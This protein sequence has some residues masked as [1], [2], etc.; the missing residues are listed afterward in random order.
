MI[1]SCLKEQVASSVLDS[2]MLNQ[3]FQWAPLVATGNPRLDVRGWCTAGPVAGH[4]QAAPTGSRSGHT[5]QDL[6]EPTATAV[7]AQDR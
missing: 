2:R 7:L 3:D 4:H 1:M 6:T 5:G